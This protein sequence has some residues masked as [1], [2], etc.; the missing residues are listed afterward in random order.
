MEAGSFIGRVDF[1]GGAYVER[2]RLT[3]LVLRDA[4]DCDVGGVE[5][6]DVGVC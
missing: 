1:E 2:Y 4:E 6:A 5:D 3:W